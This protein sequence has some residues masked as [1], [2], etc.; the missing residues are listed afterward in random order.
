[1]KARSTN[2]AEYVE[3]TI[4]C[5]PYWK[6]HLT[7]EVYRQNNNG[8]T[9]GKRVAKEIKSIIECSHEIGWIC[10][11]ELLLAAAGR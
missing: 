10:G 9:Y 6:T 8:D 2:N 4:H 5:L 1:V 3:H 7:K 11:R